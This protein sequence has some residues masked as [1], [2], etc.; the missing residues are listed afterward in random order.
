MT[1]GGGTVGD[2]DALGDAG[3]VGRGVEAGAQAGGAE[4]GGERGGGAALAV[5]AGDEDGREPKLRVAEGGGEGAHVGELELA[6]RGRGGKLLPK[7]MQ[8]ID[9][10]NKRHMT[11]LEPVSPMDLCDGYLRCAAGAVDVSSH[12][13]T[14]RTRALDRLIRMVEQEEMERQVCETQTDERR[15]FQY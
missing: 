10:C 15:S 14:K 3:E 13:S 8:S 11:I 4:D 9:R 1:T 5:G 2:A 12:N 6:A 7:P